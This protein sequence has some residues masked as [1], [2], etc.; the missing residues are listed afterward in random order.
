MKKKIKP[1]TNHEIE[2]VARPAA[3]GGVGIPNFR[4]VF[5][6]DSLASLSSRENEC[7]IINLDDSFGG[8]T[9]WVAYKF[10]SSSVKACFYFDSLG[11]PPP[12]EFIRYSSGIEI[13]YN[14]S[15][16]QPRDSVICGHLCLY[17]LTYLEKGY[18]FL[19]IILHLL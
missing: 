14:I 4:G 17:V 10:F 11:L 3:S 7:G 9:H 2:E 16:I 13:N 18:S 1:L 19:D 12:Q 8:G 5:M 15:E 6:R